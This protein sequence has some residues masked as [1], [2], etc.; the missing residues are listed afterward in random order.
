MQTIKINPA[1]ELLSPELLEK[2]NAYWRAANYFSVGQIFLH[3]NPLL[4]NH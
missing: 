2:M 4:K 1:D 3:E